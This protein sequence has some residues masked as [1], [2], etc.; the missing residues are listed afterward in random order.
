MSRVITR[1]KE[2]YG[3]ETA[4]A[5]GAAVLVS[6]AFIFSFVGALHEPTPHRVPI[7]VSAQVP[8]QVVAGVESGGALEAVPVPDPDAAA[9]KIDDRDAYGSLT[10]DRSGLVLTTAPAA[11]FAVSQ[12]LEG[13]LLPQLEAAGPT[14]TAVV[15]PLPAGDSRGNVLYFLVVGWVF[16]GYF[17]AIL[18]GLAGPSR[19]G[20][21]EVRRRLVSLLVVA[22]L[23]AP[24]GMAIAAAFAGWSGG[25]ALVALIGFLTVAA[26]GVA[27]IALQAL[28]GTVGVGAAILLFVC[29]GNPSAG[30]TVPPE[31]LPGFWRFFG[32]VLPNGAAVTAVR[33]AV[34]FPEASLATPLIVLAAW[35]LVGAALGSFTARVIWGRF[36]GE[37]AAPAAST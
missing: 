24:G 16:A 31:L 15:H 17:G 4:K 12:F 10:A 5:V 32:E 3:R 14:T 2:R 28:L 33:G 19:P 21:A 23:A 30:G 11:S 20:A 22:L 9:T 29:L 37:G 34:Y 8:Q 26:V 13:Q 6:L 18:L 25:L 27:T 1:A 36:R 35:S 7:A